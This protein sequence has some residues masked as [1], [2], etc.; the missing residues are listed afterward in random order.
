MRFPYVSL[1]VVPVFFWGLMLALAN[2]ESLGVTQLDARGMHGLFIWVVL[3]VGGIGSMFVMRGLDR[4]Q[5]SRGQS[6][7]NLTSRRW[8]AVV[9]GML[10]FGAIFAGMV[11]I[12]LR[13]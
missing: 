1:V 5:A 9:F 4:A 7:G 2:A 10:H 11:L 3:L 12:Q 13:P 8:L 6:G